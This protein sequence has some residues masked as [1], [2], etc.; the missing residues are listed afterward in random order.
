MSTESIN[1]NLDLNGKQVKGPTRLNIMAQASGLNLQFSSTNQKTASNHITPLN[2]FQTVH[3]SNAIFSQISLKS[4]A[5]TNL[6][7]EERK[8]IDKLAVLKHMGFD[9]NSTT[10]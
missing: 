9:P 6:F 10:V 2:K 4:S 1:K 5:F 3:N 7:E 8:P